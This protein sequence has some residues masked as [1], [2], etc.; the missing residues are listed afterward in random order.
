[1]IYN[2]KYKNMKKKKDLLTLAGSWKMLDIKA[3]ELM[4]KIYKER[5]IKMRTAIKEDI[6]WG[7]SESNPKKI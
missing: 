3:K 7:L 5:K 4:D 2:R 1:M 6:N